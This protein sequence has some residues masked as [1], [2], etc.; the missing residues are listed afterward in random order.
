MLN[1]KIDRRYDEKHTKFTS[2][3]DPILKEL[4]KLTGLKQSRVIGKEEFE[5]LTSNITLYLVKR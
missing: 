4:A 2:P 3:S 5:R 1:R